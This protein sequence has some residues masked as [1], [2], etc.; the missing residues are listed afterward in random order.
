MIQQQVPDLVLTDVMMPGLSGFDLLK[1]IRADPQTKAVPI[2]LLS[3]RAGEEAAVEG[4]AAGADDYLIKPFAAREL[5]AHVAAQL[6]MADL[7]HEVTLKEIELAK[8]EERQRLARDLHDAVNQSLFTI[9]VL[10]QSLPRLWQNPPQRAQEQLAQLSAIT[11][12]AMA[13]MRALLSELRPEVISRTSLRELLGQLTDIV[14]GRSRIV[15]SLAIEDTGDLPKDAHI[16]LYRIA[17]EALNNIIKH[18]GASEASIEL[19]YQQGQVELRI[20]DNGKGFNLPEISKGLG[21]DGMRERA[22]LI[23]AALEVTSAVGQGTEVVVTWAPAL[24]G[25]AK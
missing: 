22:T 5:L 11:R 7:R 18:S 1:A 15:V 21:L 24:A 3:A 9:N 19:R 17:Q 23:G 10:A 25:H 14:R 13:E 6:T 2:I 8:L 16:A 4:L 20:K 12:S